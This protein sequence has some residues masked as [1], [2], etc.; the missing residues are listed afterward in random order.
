MS[1]DTNASRH[2]KCF[3]PLE[4]VEPLQRSPYSKTLVKLDFKLSSM[5]MMYIFHST[6]EGPQK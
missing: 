5:E 2:L 3:D 1:D 4:G 6:K